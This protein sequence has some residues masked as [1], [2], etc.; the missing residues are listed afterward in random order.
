MFRFT[1]GDDCLV[2]SVSDGVWEGVNVVVAVDFY[3]FAGGIA[4]HEAVMAPL[5]VLFQLRFE[6]DVNTA[7]QVLV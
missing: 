1:L 7:V 4:Y 5:E 3:C 2:E 6:L